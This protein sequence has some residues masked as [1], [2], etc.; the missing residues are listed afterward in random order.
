MVNQVQEV[1]DEDP[2]R[3]MRKIPRDLGVSNHLIRI[4]VKQNIIFKSYSLR[5]GQM[6]MEETKHRRSERV[7]L[8]LFK[9]KKPPVP[10][11]KEVSAS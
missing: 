9:L 1:I 2:S 10:W 6:L 8:L 7:K 11:F 5:R 4:I 3:S